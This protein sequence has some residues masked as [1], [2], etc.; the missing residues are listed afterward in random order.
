METFRVIAATSVFCLSSYL[1]YDL[2]AQG[3][4]WP[5]LIFC[6]AG[7]LAAHYIWPKK[8]TDN[9]GWYD[10]LEVLIDLPYRAVAMAIRGIGKL[11]R[12]ADGDIGID[13]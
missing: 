2:F 6:V 9:N 3:F 12:H 10:V 4:S 8:H 13:L 7:Y 1:V 5:T 11:F